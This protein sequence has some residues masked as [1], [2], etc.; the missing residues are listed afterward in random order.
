MDYLALLNIPQVTERDNYI[1]ELEI[2]LEEIHLALKSMN[3]NKCPGTDG[4]PVEF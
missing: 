1:L 4:L 2:L 3:C